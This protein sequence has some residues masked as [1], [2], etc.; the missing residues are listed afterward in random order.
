MKLK[1]DYNFYKENANFNQYLIEEK[2]LKL[3]NIM[4]KQLKITIDQARKLYSDM[5]EM[6]EVIL[7]SFTMNELF[8]P[9]PITW[10]EIVLDREKSSWINPSSNI[11]TIDTITSVKYVSAC[12]NLISDTH[13]AIKILALCQI[14]IIADYYNS[15]SVKGKC[16]YLPVYNIDKNEIIAKPHTT[17]ISFP[18]Y[19]NKESDLTEAIKNNLE[20]FKNALL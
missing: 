3:I 17:I 9:K 4:E 10:Q 2:G 19:F 14:S 13:S 7:N 18:F 8:P 11:A 5:P 16:R 6:K 12:K 15:K 20:I 1:R